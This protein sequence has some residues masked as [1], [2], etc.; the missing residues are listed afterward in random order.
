MALCDRL[1][2][3]FLS[4]W[5]LTRVIGLSSYQVLSELDKDAAILLQHLEGSL[6]ASLVTCFEYLILPFLVIN[7]SLCVESRPVT[8]QPKLAHH[9]LA[10]TCLL[11]CF[12]TERMRHSLINADRQRSNDPTSSLRGLVAV[13][14]FV[15]KGQRRRTGRCS[16]RCEQ[17]QPG[18]G[19]R[20]RT[21]ICM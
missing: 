3:R 11:P 1:V 21:A 17:N 18:I 4:D 9:R 5:M 6:G 16:G 10:A 15:G 14:D 8:I 19:P 7:R 12:E 2:S 20:L 13:L